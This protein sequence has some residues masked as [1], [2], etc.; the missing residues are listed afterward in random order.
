MNDHRAVFGYANYD[1]RGLAVVIADSTDLH[2]PEG[3]LVIRRT[4]LTVLEVT[5]CDD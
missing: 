5:N 4:A 3:A 1:L 2:L